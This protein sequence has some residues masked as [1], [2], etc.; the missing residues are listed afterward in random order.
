LFSLE[1]RRL[2]GGL[3]VVYSSLQGE[4][5]DSSDLCSLV[6]ATGLQ[7]TVWKVRLGIRQ[8]STPRD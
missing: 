6:T 4:Q 2:R 1:Q 8:G 3:M 5:R 7:G